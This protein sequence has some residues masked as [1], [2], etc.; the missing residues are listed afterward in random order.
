MPLGGCF[1][2]PCAPSGEH[3]PCLCLGLEQLMYMPRF[4]S[5]TTSGKAYERQ[6]DH[7]SDVGVLLTSTWKTY[8][9]T[10]PLRFILGVN[11]V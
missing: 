8:R 9:N 4:G 10:Y 3:G 7:F 2:L 6:L 11:W 5:S 1:V